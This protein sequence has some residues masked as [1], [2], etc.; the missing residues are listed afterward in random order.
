MAKTLPT[1]RQIEVLQWIADGCPDGVMTD[2]KSKVSAYALDSRNLVRI[3]RRKNPW[4]AEITDPGKQLLA[5]GGAVAMTSAESA[6]SAPSALPPSPARL[7][8][9][10][11]APVKS[12]TQ[13]MMDRLLMEHTI[14][15]TSAE[16]RSYKRLVSVARQKKLFPDDM[17]IVLSS[18]W[19]TPCSV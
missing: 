13:Q 7:P 19:S 1:E 18:T 17:E 10:P 16:M 9:E 12:A 3:R 2:P 15:F 14:E 11:K 6:L 4:I 5:D 8:R